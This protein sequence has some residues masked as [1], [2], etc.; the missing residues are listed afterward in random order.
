M[1]GYFRVLCVLCL[2]LALG[3]CRVSRQAA[4][5]KLANACEAIVRLF[6]DANEEF[7]IRKQDFVF[8]ETDN[9]LKLRTVALEGYLVVDRGREL[10]RTYKCSFTEQFGPLG[11]GYNATYDTIELEGKVYGYRDGKATGDLTDHLRI[12]DA[13]TKSLMQ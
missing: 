12:T 4:D 1:H 2:V 3:G 6:L 11:M 5:Q 7:I 10:D 8:N 9:G 13:V